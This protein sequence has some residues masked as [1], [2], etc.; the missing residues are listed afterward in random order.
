VGKVVAGEVACL[1]ALVFMVVAVGLQEEEAPEKG[2]RQVFASQ[3]STVVPH[4]ISCQF[5]LSRMSLQHYSPSIL[6]AA[7]GR[8]TLRVCV[9]RPAV[10][11]KSPRHQRQESESS[12]THDDYD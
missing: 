5:K 9:L 2:W 8:S 12:E 11:S 3:W 6:R 7:L 4:L 10:S 1:V